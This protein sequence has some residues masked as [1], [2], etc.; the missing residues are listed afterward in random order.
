MGLQEL[1]ESTCVRLAELMQEAVGL[2]FSTARRALVASRLAPRLQ[3][4]GL[5]S[6]DA[7]VALIA[8]AEGAAERQLAIDLLTTGDSHFFRE[9]AHFDLLESEL[10]RLRLPRLRLW[11]AAAGFGDEA[12]SLAM[13]LADLQRAGRIGADWSILGTDVSGRALRAGF[14]AI[15]AEDRLRQ[16]T[17]ERLRRYGVRGKEGSAGLIQMQAALRER[18]DFMRLDL[19]QP[20]GEL[21]IFDAVFLRHALLYF[22]ASTRRAVVARVLAQLRPGGLFFIGAGED[23]SPAGLQKLAPGAF[24]K[25]P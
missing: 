6:Y 10:S 22:D 18:V 19:R 25:L 12:Y 1:R 23:L 17:P 20:V 3:R 11:S 9:S 4:L 5:D 7:Y 13:L 2:S 21:G 14:E 16:L 15:Y 24:R 8:G